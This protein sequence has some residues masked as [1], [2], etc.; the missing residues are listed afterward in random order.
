MPS[1]TIQHTHCLTEL[2]DHFMTYIQLYVLLFLA[3]VLLS[4]GRKVTPLP[5]N[6]SRQL[7]QFGVPVTAPSVFCD[8]GSIK[9]T[10]AISVM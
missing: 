4:S 1:I 2:D 9:R 6:S 10:T 3:L 5:A 8:G 7:G